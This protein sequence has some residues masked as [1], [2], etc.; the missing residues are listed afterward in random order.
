[1]YARLLDVKYSTDEAPGFLKATMLPL[2]ISFHIQK[3]DSLAPGHSNTENNIARI[4]Y[5]FE[6]L[7]SYHF[8][9]RLMSA[10]SLAMARDVRGRSRG[11]SE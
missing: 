9:W 11:L 7:G 3:E 2:V 6:E 8:I 5:M 1:M 10:Y 4:T